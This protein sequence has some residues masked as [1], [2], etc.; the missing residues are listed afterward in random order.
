MCVGLVIQY[1]VLATDFARSGILTPDSGSLKDI[2]HN[3]SYTIKTTHLN[4]RLGYR[5]HIYGQIIYPN[6][7]DTRS[8]DFALH[9]LAI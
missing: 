4:N 1:I 6:H 3:N 7:D 9:C 5:L 2:K 8:H